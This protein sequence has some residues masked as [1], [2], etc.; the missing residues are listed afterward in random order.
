MRRP[1]KRFGAGMA[2]SSKKR[3]VEKGAKGEGSSH[4]NPTTN[5]LAATSKDVQAVTNWQMLQLLHKRS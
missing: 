1:R 2:F 5:F 4:Q 3:M